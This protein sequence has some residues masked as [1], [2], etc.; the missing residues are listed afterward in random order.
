MLIFGHKWVKNKE[1]KKV[2]SKEAIKNITEN[3]IV[4][5]EPLSDSIKLAQYCQ[6]NSIPFAVTINSTREALFSNA[7][8]A[9]FVICL[10]EDSPGIQAIAQEY[11]FD[12]KVLALISSDKE[13]EK[14]ARLSIDGVILPEAIGLY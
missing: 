3:D 4:L 12:T 8:N 1:F 2:F 6:K 11:L 9:L 5:L 7:L 14:M 13:I 10:P